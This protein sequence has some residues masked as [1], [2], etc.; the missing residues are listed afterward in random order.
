MSALGQKQTLVRFRVMSA[1][2]SPTEKFLILQKQK[3][4]DREIFDLKN[5]KPIHR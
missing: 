2:P 5:R 3:P 4:A 1:L